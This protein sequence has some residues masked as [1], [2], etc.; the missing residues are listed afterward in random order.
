MMQSQDGM[1][2]GMDPRMQQAMMQSMANSMD[3]RMQQAMMQN[4]D[5]MMQSQDA[6]MQS[7]QNRDAM[8]QSQDAMMQSREAMMQQ[9]MD[10][11]A[12]YA[13]MQQA[14]MMGKGGSQY[15]QNEYASDMK[16]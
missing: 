14:A 5:A 7:R 15:E 1:A 3:P 12:Y 4:R 6:M 13:A 10:Q 16:G 11:R 9:S 2:N 8:M